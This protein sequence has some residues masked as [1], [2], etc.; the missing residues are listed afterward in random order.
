MHVLMF[1]LLK[2]IMS[3]VYVSEFFYYSFL[4][5]RKQEL[6]VKISQELDV[7][8]CKFFCQKI[9]THAFEITQSFVN[10]LWLLIQT[11]NRDRYKTYIQNLN[12]VFYD[13][14][15]LFQKKKTT[16]KIFTVKIETLYQLNSKETN[17]C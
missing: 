3:F 14:D 1:D 4:Y 5:V 10:L 6:D 7:K 15:I 11:W 8:L 9:L 13:L 12:Y 17:W 2:V 16:N